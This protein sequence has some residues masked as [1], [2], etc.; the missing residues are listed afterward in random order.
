MRKLIEFLRA[1]AEDERIPLQNRVVLGG[2]L[3]YLMTPVD[4]IPDIVPILGWLDD[5]FVA[6]IVLDYVFNSTDTGIIL[7]HYPW[8]KKNFQKMKTRVETLSWLVPS[9]VKNLLFQQARQIAVK[10][11]RKE[12]ILKSKMTSSE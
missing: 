4:I 5:V 12:E 2:L 9:G 1:V 8:N 7:E 3:L 11:S 10:Q 6:L